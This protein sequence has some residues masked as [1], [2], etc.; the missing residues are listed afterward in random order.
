MKKMMNISLSLIVAMVLFSCVS[1]KKYKSAVAERDQLKSQNADL[2]NQVSSLQKQVT[3]ANSKNQALTSEYNKYKAECQDCQQK[4]A[5]V[6]STLYDMS[7]T[8][9]EIEKKLEA[10]LQ[11]FADHGVDVYSKDGNI[12]VSLAEGLMYKSGSAKLD[13][14]AKDALGQLAAVLNEYPKLQVIVV[15]NTDMTKVK[16]DVDNWSLSTE[17]ANGVVR[18]LSNDYGVDP[19]RLISAGQGKFNPV[20]ENTNP[21]GRA[22]NRR[23]EIILNPD[24]QRIWKE[25]KEQK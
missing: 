2:N 21:D 24:L 25:T 13:A 12:H 8:M 5:A 9:D 15:G 7:K 17:R 18:I 19:T 14:K 23:T 1:Q 22:K 10:A 20:A 11:N 3:D 4:L 6:R 16:G